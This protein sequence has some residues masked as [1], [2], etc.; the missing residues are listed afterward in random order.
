MLLDERCPSYEV[1]IPDTENAMRKALVLT[2]MCACKGGLDSGDVPEPL[3]MAERLGADRARAGRVMNE[4][5]L[6]GGVSAD[7]EIGDLKIYNDL[8]QFVF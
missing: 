1:R 3:D 2:W 7:G 8:V 4:A 6:L 5:A